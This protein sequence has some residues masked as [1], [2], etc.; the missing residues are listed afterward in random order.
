MQVRRKAD[1]RA[2]IWEQVFCWETETESL[3]FK[4]EQPKQ[5]FSDISAYSYTLAKML[6]DALNRIFQCS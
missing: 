3:V 4:E 1:L 5:S 6:T 2:L